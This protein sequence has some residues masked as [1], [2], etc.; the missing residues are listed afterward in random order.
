MG[1]R[2]LSNTSLLDLSTLAKVWVSLLMEKWLRPPTT[3]SKV[4]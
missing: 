4:L 3:A 2:A 1:A